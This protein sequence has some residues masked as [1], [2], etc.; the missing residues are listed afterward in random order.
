VA[1][2]VTVVVVDGL[3]SMSVLLM[4]GRRK[5]LGKLTCGTVDMHHGLLNRG[6]GDSLSSPICPTLCDLIVWS[7]WK[8]PSHSDDCNSSRC[9][10]TTPH[11]AGKELFS[12][13]GTGGLF[14]L[15]CTSG[16]TLL[17]P[18]RQMPAGASAS[19]AHS[20]AS[21]LSEYTSLECHQWYS[22][23]RSSEDAKHCTW[24]PGS[25]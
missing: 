13:F 6:R 12:S 11:V 22:I 25:L 7:A 21:H 20:T 8:H 9:S 4:M 18:P 1:C 16:C 15:E 23:Q 17:M 19:T 2:D 14:L 24:L 5:L 3:D 10:R